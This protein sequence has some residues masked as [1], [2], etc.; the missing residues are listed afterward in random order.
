MGAHKLN[1][2]NLAAHDIL[3]GESTV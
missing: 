1:E 3:I 2:S